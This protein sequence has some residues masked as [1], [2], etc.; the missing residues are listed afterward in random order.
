MT[1]YGLILNDLLLFL[2]ILIT[3]FSLSN[4][5]PGRCKESSTNKGG[6]TRLQTQIIFRR[7]MQVGYILGASLLL[8][9]LFRLAL[10]NQLLP[11]TLSSYFSVEKTAAHAWFIFWG[12]AFFLYTLEYR[13]RSAFFKNGATA[14]LSPLLSS[15]L[16]TILLLGTGLWILK[17][18]LNWHSTHILVSATALTAIAGFALK[19]TIGDLLAGI[20]LHLSHAVIPSHWIRLPKF[21]IEGEVIIANWRETRVRTTGGHT[22]VVPNSLLAREHFHNMSWPDLQ[23]RH[24]LNFVVGFA[25]NPEE[26]EAA[27][28]RSATGIP[29]ILPDKAPQVIIK[30]YLDFG[31]QYQLR[32]WSKTFHDPSSLENGIYQA[33]WQEFTQQGIEYVDMASALLMQQPK[34]GAP[35]R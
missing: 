4:I 25:N 30:A 26:V 16:R 11:Q 24:A 14:P 6:V 33:V 3:S 9:A 12:A 35:T 1:S 7:L 2:L 28:L 32:V 34:K 31:I 18:V 27:L 5:Y 13:L 10:D 22:Y 17:Y 29:N 8:D 21:N 19:G 23:R 15:I 20:S